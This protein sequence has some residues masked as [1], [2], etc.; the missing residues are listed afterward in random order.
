[1]GARQYFA[2]D[3]DFGFS[4]TLEETARFWPRDS[5]LK[6]VVRIIRRFHPQII[7]SIFSGTPRDG[8]GQHQMAGWAAREAFD[9]A[10]DPKRFPELATQEGLQP[11]TPL[12]FYRNA[13]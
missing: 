12:K 6:D 9:A 10:G 5:V 3:F 11:W 2:R 4:K 1:D 7:V 13:R 8:H